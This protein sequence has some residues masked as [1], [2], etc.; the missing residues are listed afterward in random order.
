MKNCNEIAN[1]LLTRRN[2][3]VKAKKK[4]QKAVISTA[5][6]LCIVAL[7]SFG[8]WK[9]EK[10]DNVSV[11]VPKNAVGKSTE[12]TQSVTENGAPEDRIWTFN[13]NEI[14][15]VEYGCPRYF[16]PTLYYEEKCTVDETA[17][18]FGIDLTKL[19][20]P[21]GLKYSGR[22]SFTIIKSNDG[23]IAEDCAAFH[24]TDGKDKKA[25]IYASR[26]GGAC[27]N[28]YMLETEYETMMKNHNLKLISMLVGGMK[29]DKNLKYNNFYVVNF[30]YNG[31]KYHIEAEN[32]DTSDYLTSKS[33][34]HQIIFPI[35]NR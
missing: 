14:S 22:D 10:T 30:E 33:A 34:L 35:V 29:T 4:K 23:K 6:C 13:I 17:E 20:M 3:Y 24:Y 11:E 25:I 5:S 7:L 27:N 8:V 15:S 9:Y 2:E 28:V 1:E 19:E 18:Y 21:D 16:D 26:V 32:C 12:T 31:V